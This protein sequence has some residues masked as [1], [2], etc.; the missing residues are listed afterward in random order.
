MKH[1]SGVVL[2]LIASFWFSFRSVFSLF[3]IL[4]FATSQ[5][6]NAAEVVPGTTASPLPASC[7]EADPANGIVLVGSVQRLSLSL[8]KLLDALQNPTKPLCADN[9]SFSLRVIEFT[10]ADG[11]MPGAEVTTTT[12][13]VGEL[14]I[15]AE[16]ITGSVSSQT[17]AAQA[18][19]QF[20]QLV[21]QLELLLGRPIEVIFEQVTHEVLSELQKE[22]KNL[23]QKIANLLRSSSPAE[24]TEAEEFIS[25]GKLLWE[26]LT[27]PGNLAKAVIRFA[28]NS[29]LVGVSLYATG[30]NA[31]S[32]SHSAWLGIAAGGGSFLLMAGNDL[33]KGF[34]ASPFWWKIPTQAHLEK[35]SRSQQNQ[36]AKQ[37]LQEQSRLF[38]MGVVKDFFVAT[39]YLVYFQTV[40]YALGEVPDT[41]S[42][43]ST[44]FLISLGLTLTTETNLT[45]LNGNLTRQAISRL[46]AFDPTTPLRERKIKNLS[47]S[48]A[49]FQ[50]A[51]L[52]VFQ[53]LAVQG[54]VGAQGSLVTLSVLGLPNYYFLV[55][56]SPESFLGRVRET[57]VLPVFSRGIERLDAVA[58]RLKRSAMGVCGK[59]SRLF[60]NR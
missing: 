53:I 7:F 43:A 37:I 17:E 8:Q 22:A 26:S 28:I 6:G 27:N 46:S 36:S 55:M 9:I 18:N 33:Y 51:V 11:D 10:P 5:R 23:A 56:A 19:L 44:D 57:Y 16:E 15:L 59:V 50:S 4:A 58:E 40:A 14:A 34:L 41:W 12:G 39:G 24:L 30:E 21:T 20:R 60:S 31:M 47:A 29:T 32:L 48:M 49:L 1:F 35:L 38:S 54:H 25:P 45:L 13:Q 52:T 42:K 3:L 2:E